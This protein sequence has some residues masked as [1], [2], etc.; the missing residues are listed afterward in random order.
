MGIIRKTES[1]EILLN[2]FQDTET[3]LSTVELITR[4]GKFMNKTTIYRIL[5]KLEDDGILHSFI[6][7]DGVKRFARCKSCSK[8]NHSDVH[9][10]FQCISCGKSECLDI[11]VNIPEMSNREVLFSQLLIKGKCDLCMV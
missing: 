11:E 8:S 6:G 7:F 10:H 2:E 5:D 4:L 9:P 3:A 1:V